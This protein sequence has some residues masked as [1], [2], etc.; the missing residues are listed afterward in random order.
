MHTGS[1]LCGKVK[2]QFSGEIRRFHHCHCRTCR[3]VHATVYG[4][5]ALT[6]AAEFKVT[7]GEEFISSYTSSPSKNRYFCIN[8]GTHVFA[9]S[10]RNPEDV[11]LRIGAIDGD[12][13]FKARGHIWVSHK[14]DWYD[15][16]DTLP[17][18]ERW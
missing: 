11:I 15:I 6:D 1:C 5:S 7:E 13:G 2:F 17:Q 3:K 12:I 8:C 16:E 10:E 18:S 4:S 9:H 14:P